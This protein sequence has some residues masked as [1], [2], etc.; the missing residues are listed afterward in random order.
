MN[1]QSQNANQH[2][3][4]HSLMHLFLWLLSLHK[5]KDCVLFQFCVT[6]YWCNACTTTMLFGME[7]ISSSIKHMLKIND[8]NWICHGVIKI[9]RTVFAFKE[10]IIS[11]WYKL[12]LYNK[13]QMI[14]WV[15]Q[16]I[17]EQQYSLKLLERKWCPWASTSTLSWF[18]SAFSFQKLTCSQ[19]DFSKLAGDWVCECGWKVYED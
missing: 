17:L 13:W 6:C 10:F 14:H 18:E 7:Y 19:W 8:K 3:Y 4:R 5:G 9:N 16:V 1:L 12:L 15:W 2:K 11:M